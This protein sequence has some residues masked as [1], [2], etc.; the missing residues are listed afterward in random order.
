MLK[1]LVDVDL[2]MIVLW[3]MMVIFLY[4][5]GELNFATVTAIYWVNTAVAS[6]FFV[7]YFVYRMFNKAID[8]KINEYEQ[9]VFELE[10]AEDTDEQRE[11][12]QVV[13]LKRKDLLYNFKLDFS[14]VSGAAGMLLLFNF[15][16]ILVVYNV[17]SGE[18]NW[19]YV[20]VCSTAY[21]IST[22]YS[23]TKG[24]LII[25]FNAMPNVK[26]AFLAI[27]RIFPLLIL[28]FIL[29]SFAV[30]M[31]LSFII[32]KMVLDI[33]LYLL[34]QSKEVGEGAEVVPY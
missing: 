22:L 34:Y 5:L 17:L 30:D 6:F 29:V 27:G 11:Q 33:L 32:A 8:R 9:E 25:K 20:A 19:P 2:I 21:L 18:V 7:A 4:I 23:V 3:N 24:G 1:R 14:Q 31:L 28:Q 15:F 10:Q 26:I 12:I 13:M 16:S